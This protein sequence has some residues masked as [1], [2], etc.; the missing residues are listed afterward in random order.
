MLEAIYSSITHRIDSFLEKNWV[1]K[2]TIC[3][4]LCVVFFSSPDISKIQSLQNGS[5]SKVIQKQIEQP[6][7]QQNYSSES[8]FSK[9]TFRL[10]MPIVAK[11]LHIG[12]GGLLI[13]QYFFG[14]LF[15]Y[16]SAKLSF[17]YSKEKIAPFLFVIGFAG[18]Y[19]GKSFFL[20]YWAFF[21]GTAFFFLLLSLYFRTPILIFFCLSFAFWTDERALVAAFGVLVFHL[22]ITNKD[23]INN[24]F[25]WS[26]KQVVPIFAAIIVYGGLRWYLTNRFGLTIGSE[27]IGPF[28]T[29][30]NFIKYM[31]LAIFMFFES[32]WLLIIA[33]F[34]YLN[35]KTVRSLKTIGV[36]FLLVLLC[37]TI[38]ALS[39]GDM[40]RS[41]SYAFV[42][43][44][45]SFLIIEKLKVNKKIVH[46]LML[47]VASF[48]YLIP[49]YSVFG[50]KIIW[51]RSEFFILF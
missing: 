42:F 46:C 1:V 34:L 11:I 35:Y 37:Q 19:V 4:F 6:F 31:P 2:T 22:F 26:L 8:H 7:I 50:N 28:W 51:M 13:L 5:I 38:V 43:C 14:I 18:I 12:V 32:Y 23:N 47:I 10:F 27:Y 29:L 21:D 40:V 17:L 36:L 41:G 9:R 16:F 44:F 24:S 30:K 45:T 33:G 15:F 39:V 20:D 3:S 48:A 49:T 25:E